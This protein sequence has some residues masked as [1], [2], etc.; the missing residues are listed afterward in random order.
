MFTSLSYFQGD[1]K[2]IFTVSRKKK[3]IER[4]RDYLPMHIGEKKLKKLRTRGGGRKLIALSGNI[5]NITVKGKT[6]KTKI[7]TV[8]ENSADPHFVRRNI[9]T[10]GAIINTELGKARVTSKPGRDGIVNAISLGDKK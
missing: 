1:V 6:Q 4:A 8:L 2:N 10:K 9:V 7:L 3:K 5:A